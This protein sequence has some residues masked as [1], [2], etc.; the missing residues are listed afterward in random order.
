[1]DVGIA[2]PNAVPGATAAQMTE[3]ARR[4]EARGLVVLHG[5]TLF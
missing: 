2:L 3:W 5:V 1:M 4:A